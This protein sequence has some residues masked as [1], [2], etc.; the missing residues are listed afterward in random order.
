MIR[1]SLIG[2]LASKRAQDEASMT[3]SPYRPTWGVSI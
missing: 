2:E 3:E 1:L